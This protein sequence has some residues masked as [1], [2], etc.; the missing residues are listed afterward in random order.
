MDCPSRTERRKPGG[1]RL[2]PR[3]AEALAFLSQA[4]P[5][6]TAHYTALLGL[7]PPIARRSL[8]KLRDLGLVRVHVSAMHEPN[9]FTL[10]P[11]AQPVLAR[12]LDQSPEEF[13]VLR[14]IGRVDLAHHEAVVD[15][16]V[17]LKVAASRSKRLDLE[18]FTFERDIRR[19]L[20]TPRQVMLPDAVAVL[21]E[22]SGERFAVA[23]EVDLATENPSWVATHKVIPYSKLRGIGRPLL[24]CNRWV[25]CCV[26]TSTHRRNRLVQAAWSVGV[27]EGL[28]H[29]STLTAISGCSIL[30]PA[31]W[32]TPRVV[33]DG[34]VA[35]LIAESPFQTGTSNRHNCH[36]GEEGGTACF[37]EVFGVGKLGCFTSGGTT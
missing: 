3:E 11:A 26:T 27:P 25:V 30:L 9:R 5:I 24:G 28:W 29:Y 36:A 13:R 32:V 4:Q 19:R 35:R 17:A 18:Q 20:G 1:A 21:A 16:Y 15:L 6:T 14:G 34:E 12:A 23:F 7:S 10:T 8:R 33:M 37:D 31:T 2:T 22:E